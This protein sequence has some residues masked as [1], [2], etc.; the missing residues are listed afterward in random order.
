MHQESAN[1]MFSYSKYD[2]KPVWQLHFSFLEN[3]KT[4]KLRHILK[5]STLADTKVK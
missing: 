3:N 2:T 4:N 1:K 5:P